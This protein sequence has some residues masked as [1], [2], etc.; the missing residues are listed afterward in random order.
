MMKSFALFQSEGATSMG[1]VEKE[2]TL[3]R[4][5]DMDEGGRKVNFM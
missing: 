5:N 1:G 2:G 3:Q 4:K